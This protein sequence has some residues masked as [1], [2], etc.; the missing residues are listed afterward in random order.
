MSQCPICNG[1]G[2]VPFVKNGKVIPNVKLFCKCHPIY[3]DNAHYGIPI[4]TEGKRPPTRGTIPKGRAHLYIDDFDFPMSYSVYRSLCQEHGWQDP[5][6]DRQIE[7]EEPS[8]Q[9]V[10]HIHRHIHYTSERFQPSEKKTKPSTYK[11]L[12]S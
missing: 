1:S 5:G 3:G 7:L 8:P 9:V 4:A 6:P 2:F 10:E 11:G 12:P